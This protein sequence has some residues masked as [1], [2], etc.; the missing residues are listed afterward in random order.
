MTFVSYASNIGVGD[1][2]GTADVYWR[3]RIAGTTER[4]S[5]STAGVQNSSVNQ[6]PTISSDGR[7]VAFESPATTL[8]AGDTNNAFDVYLRDRGTPPPMSYCTAGT[9]TN[10]CS[11]SITANAN[12]S[13]SF[14]NACNITV[15]NVEGQQPGLLFYGVNNTGFVPLPWGAGTSWLCVKAPTER[16][17]V[18]SSGGTAG[19]CNGGFAL[20]WNAFQS[21]NSTALGNPWL[22]GNKAYVQAWFRDPPAPKTTSLSGAVELTYQP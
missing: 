12:P 2:N 21:A 10:G 18:Q 19:L 5:V 6:Y 13:V 20:D 9:T 16:T 15:T 17:G 3:D 14:A 8:V 11:A 1:T 22:V 7:F 4:V